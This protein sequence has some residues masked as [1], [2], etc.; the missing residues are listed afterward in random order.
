M[1]KYSLVTVLMACSSIAW[2]NE[3]PTDILDYDYIYASA[4]SGSLNEDATAN[5]NASVYALGVSYMMNDNW[6][7][8]GDY[9]ARFI[10]PDDTT[11]RIDTLMG[12]I[13]YR[14][15]LMQD[16]DF[17]ASYNLGIT[18]AKVELNTNNIAVSSDT[19]LIHGGKVALNYGFAESWIASGSIQV[20]RSDLIDEEIYQTSLRY[21]VTSRFAIGGFYAHRDGNT[22]RTNELGINFLLEY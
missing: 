14:Y 3:N 20:N 7:L 5:A 19:E 12:G 16:F 21:L 18:K 22:Q 4:G 10:H 11:T 15:N 9:T 2:S 8:M 1:F 13:G 6:L 17:I